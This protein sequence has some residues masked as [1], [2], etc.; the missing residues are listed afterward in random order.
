[1][2]M[3]RGFYRFSG[4][5]GKMMVEMVGVEVPVGEF[6]GV[7]RNVRREMKKKKKKEMRREEPVKEIRENCEIC[8]GNGWGR[9]GFGT[10]EPKK[11]L[12]LTSF[13]IFIIYFFNS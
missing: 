6:E 12:I 13:F 2:K 7:K 5:A 3:L 8:G 9:C 10:W 4:D 1:M 11:Y